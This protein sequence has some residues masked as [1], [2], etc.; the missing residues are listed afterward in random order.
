MPTVCPRNRC[1]SGL[2]QVQS[3]IV[4]SSLPCAERVLRTSAV[5]WRSSH[6]CGNQQRVHKADVEVSKTT[7][8]SCLSAHLLCG[9]TGAPTQ[10][11]TQHSQLFPVSAK[12]K[13]KVHD[14][15]GSTESRASFLVWAFAPQ[16]Y[17]SHIDA[18]H[19]RQ[20]L[21]KGERLVRYEVNAVMPKGIASGR[22][23]PL[24]SAVVDRKCMLAALACQ[25]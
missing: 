9:E 23:L 17:R 6:C 11:S 21:V 25:R 19:S 7:G 1:A 10:I 14:F 22:P 3:S 20:P 2:V 12:V 24:Q 18:S 16:K 4:S 5:V 13:P 15:S 8:R